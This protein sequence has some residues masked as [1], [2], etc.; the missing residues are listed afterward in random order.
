MTDEQVG[1]YIRLICLQHQRGH[2]TEKEILSICKEYDE[3]VFSKLVKDISGK[4]YNE[5]LEDVINQR[6]AYSES[7]RKNRTSKKDINNICSTYV[8]HMENEIEN[9]DINLKS[10]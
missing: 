8:Q 5:R 1:R 4:F 2:L 6:K 10:N 7:R 3:D 9:E